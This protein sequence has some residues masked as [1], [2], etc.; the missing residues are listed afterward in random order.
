MLISP[1]RGF[2]L[3]TPNN[4]NVGNTKPLLKTNVL[5]SDT[6][7]FGTRTP[8]ILPEDLVSSANE[9][10]AKLKKLK[11]PIDEAYSVLSRTKSTESEK[12]AAYDV[13]DLKREVKI[14]T[15]V[16]I[17]GKAQ[18]CAASLGQYCGGWEFYIDLGKD[19]DVI[20]YRIELKDNKEVTGSSKLKVQKLD[21]EGLPVGFA[22]LKES[23]AYNKAV[24]TVKT[25][26][27]ALTKV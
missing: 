8:R 4:N 2:N 11:A 19:K 15:P 10:V 12:K 1:V 23:K 3:N 5:M 7:S 22:S 24:L 18:T 27:D 26:L 9:I 25:F 16:E 13:L 17:N 20:R 6:V 14:E 21:K